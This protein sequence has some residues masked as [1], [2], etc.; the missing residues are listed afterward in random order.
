MAVQLIDIEINYLSLSINWLLSV[1]RGCQLIERVVD[2]QLLVIRIDPISITSNNC[3]LPMNLNNRTS[4][5]MGA[6]M[7]APAEASANRRSSRRRHQ[8]RWFCISQDL[9]PPSGCLIALAA[10]ITLCQLLVFCWSKCVV[11]LR[12]LTALNY[13]MCD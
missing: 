13:R 6:I 12:L 9:V 7:R 10:T 8:T 2:C 1:H 3:Q 4:L 5:R 11:Y